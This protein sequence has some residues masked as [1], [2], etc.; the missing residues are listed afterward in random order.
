MGVK[1]GT[2][3]YNVGRKSTYDHKK[4]A[5]FASPEV[6]MQIQDTYRLQLMLARSRRFDD[7]SIAIDFRENIGW[8]AISPDQAGSCRS[9]GYRQEPRTIVRISLK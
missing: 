8:N 7:V 2:A 1:E 3:K 6:H 4:L 5:V 9:V